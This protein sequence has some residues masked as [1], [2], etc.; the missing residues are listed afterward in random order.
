M[1]RVLMM[2][3]VVLTVGLGVGSNAQASWMNTVFPTNDCT[4]GNANPNATYG[5]QEGMY[6]Q[7]NAGAEQDGLV[8][9]TLPTFTGTVQN[10]ML[11]L[12]L[13]TYSGNW[14]STVTVELHKTSNTQNDGTTP[15]QETTL[16]W[17]LKPAAGDLLGSIVYKVSGNGSF[18]PAASRNSAKQASQFSGSALDNYIN[19]VGSGGTISF[20]VLIPTSN[21]TLPVY[22]T[23]DTS[24]STCKP[25]LNFDVVP[26][27]VTLVLLGLGGL[28]LRKRNA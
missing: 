7:N 2:S 4:V 22:Y 16:T 5:T 25:S 19:S 15:W 27:P 13:K 17:N 9:F 3:V 10:A 28:F 21:P 1:K 20:M 14:N 11:E 26:E 6:V 23:K 8:K 24:D 12:V 18:N